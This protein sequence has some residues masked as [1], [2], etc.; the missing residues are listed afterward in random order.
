M[1]AAAIVAA[2]L[3]KKYRSQ[4]LLLVH[5]GRQNATL[6]AVGALGE[7]A[8][9]A[10][11]AD[12]REFQINSIAV[13]L[14]SQA[15]V[16]KVVDTLGPDVLFGAAPN[17]ETEGR[18]ALPDVL[19]AAIGVESA[20][21]ASRAGIIHKVMKRFSVEALPKSDVIQI[22]FDATSP[23]AAQRAVAAL[24]EA[25]LEQHV[26]LNQIPGAHEFLTRQTGDNF[27]RL[28]QAEKALLELKNETG[29]TSI[30]AQ[31]QALTRRL[32][33]L[34]ND[35]LAASAEVAAAD[36]QVLAL[37]GRLATLSETQVLA[38]TTGGEDK[39]AAGMREQV[40]ALEMKVQH[41][42]ATTKKDYFEIPQVAQELEK[43]RSI[44]QAQPPQHPQVTRGPNRCYEDLQLTLQKQEP[45]LASLRAKADI[46]RRQIAETRAQLREFNERSMKIARLQRGVEIEDAIYRKYMALAEQDRIDQ[47]L[48]TARITSVTVAEPATYDSEPVQPRPIFVLGIGFCLALF[49]G[50]TVPLLA[51]YRDR[52]LRSREEI[53]ETLR[54]P[55]LAVIPRLRQRDLNMA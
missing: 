12:N 29:L 17:Q 13:I 54:A 35:L 49:G 53:E 27:A 50:V 20:L 41:L 40:F 23:E 1:V 31:Q 4:A 45:L 14:A 47:A 5:L 8:A 42:L 52:S 26:R 37:R 36:T 33:G 15:M 44:L 19:R 3:P 51:E 18:A 46:L 39:T 6:D 22:S 25:Y 43:T 30:E 16:A 28:T 10:N 2:V 9:A 34:E 32:A 24:I 55:V 21:T 48:E 38:E 7:T 11:P